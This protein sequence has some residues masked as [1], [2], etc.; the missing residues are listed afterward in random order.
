[1]PCDRIWLINLSYCNTSARGN[2]E[3]CLSVCEIILQ[4]TLNFRVPLSTDKQ[5]VNEQIPK[6][7][8]KQHNIILNVIVLMYEL[9]IFALYWRA[10]RFIFYLLFDCNT[11][12]FFLALIMFPKRSFKKLCIFS[13]YDYMSF[14]DLSKRFKNSRTCVWSAIRLDYNLN[15]WDFF[16]FQ[17]N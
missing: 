13:C 3:L 15:G 11:S 16:I 8:T 17:G 12:V 5:S 14:S 1:M 9:M 6:E 7:K 4:G 2:D 10:F